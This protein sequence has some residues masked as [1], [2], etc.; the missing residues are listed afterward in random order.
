M[1]KGN[2]NELTPVLKISESSVTILQEAEDLISQI[3]KALKGDLQDQ[4]NLSAILSKVL[5]INERMVNLAK[6]YRLDKF[7]EI[8]NISSNLTYISKKKLYSLFYRKVKEPLVDEIIANID[9]LVALLPILFN[10][11]I[12][13]EEKNPQKKLFELSRNNN[14]IISSYRECIKSRH[15]PVTGSPL[16]NTLKI[17]KETV[18]NNA[19]FL[20]TDLLKAA[21]RSLTSKEI[22]CIFTAFETNNHKVRLN[23]L[24]CFPLESIP[25]QGELIKFTDLDFEAEMHLRAWIRTIPFNQRDNYSE[26]EWQPVSAGGKFDPSAPAVF[27]IRHD[28]VNPENMKLLQSFISQHPSN[29]KIL[30]SGFPNYDEY[31]EKS[32]LTRKVARECKIPHYELAFKVQFD[33]PNWALLFQYVAALTIDKSLYVMKHVTAPSFKSE[34]YDILSTGNYME[35]STGHDLGKMHD[36]L[37]LIMGYLLDRILRK[38]LQIP[39]IEGPIIPSQPQI[40]QALPSGYTQS[41]LKRMSCCFKSGNDSGQIDFSYRRL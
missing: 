2:S 25:S 3:N 11:Y 21:F 27:F 37:F 4:K 13:P 16:Y 6:N 8:F 19:E 9:A 40:P 33:H 7:G 39:E 30:A 24:G 35:C 23:Y 38:Q 32:Q 18:W 29:M 15:Q 5:A 34:L 28:D 1:R 12:G 14:R 31:N 22:R 20:Q 17:I 10:Y 26:R 41:F 36:I